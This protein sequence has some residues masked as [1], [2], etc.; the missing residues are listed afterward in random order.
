MTFGRGK[1]KII[2]E[3]PRSFLGYKNTGRKQIYTHVLRKD[4]AYL[5]TSLDKL[6]GGKDKMKQKGELF[7]RGILN[8]FG[9][10]NQ[11]GRINLE[12]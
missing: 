1:Y 12:R 2:K 7:V 4:I 3:L 6:L 9:I 10:N 11:L 8:L 5:G